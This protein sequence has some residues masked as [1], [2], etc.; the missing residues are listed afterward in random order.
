MKMIRP[1]SVTRIVTVILVVVLS[2]ACLSSCQGTAKE[3]RETFL[4]P[5]VRE[6]K[7]GT[8]EGCFAI[9]YS[10]PSLWEESDLVIYGRVQSWLSE[11]AGDENGVHQ[12]F[13]D[14]IVLETFKGKPSE[15]IVMLQEGSSSYT[16]EHSPIYRHG[17]EML[18][19]L[20]EADPYDSQPYEKT[21]WMPAGWPS[22]LPVFNDDDNVR[23]ALDF[24]YFIPN[25][26]AEA[27]IALDNYNDLFAQDGPKKEAMLVTLDR[28]IPD[29]ASC[30]REQDD[31]VIPGV[32]RVD[33]I[34]GQM[35]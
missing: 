31:Y 9:S 5:L 4:L 18:L 24:Y 7:L 6:G 26:G 29:L 16:Y 14:V 8:L 27:N 13:H 25:L 10:F 12:T 34:L 32:Y 21:Y 35:R 23:Y 28:T 2:V 30:L 15:R 33:D 1:K 20:R 3:P 19:F 22:A 11:I 17:E